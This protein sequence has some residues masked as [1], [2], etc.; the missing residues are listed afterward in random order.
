MIRVR[1]FGTIDELEL[2]LQ[3]G[4]ISTRKI[5]DRYSGVVGKTLIF[6]QPTS[7]TAT[8]TTVNNQVDPSSLSFQEVKAQLEAAI[9]GL[10]V[11]QRG[12]ALVL[13]QT[14]PTVGGGVTIT[15]GTGRSE[16]GLGENSTE[17]GKVYDTPNGSAAPTVPYVVNAYM[18]SDNSHVLITQE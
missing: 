3:G 2:F 9:T 1:K 4:I 6:T 10:T 8:F 12:G 13:I 11:K 16:L 15:G 17:A 18:S 14:T 5:P 7:A